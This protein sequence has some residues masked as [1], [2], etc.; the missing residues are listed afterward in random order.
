[1]N[2]FNRTSNES[3]FTF[4]KC[5]A[6][7]QVYHVD[8]TKIGNNRCIS[9]SITSQASSSLIEI[10]RPLFLTADQN[11]LQYAA[12]DLAVKEGFPQ[13][14]NPDSVL[15]LEP[16]VLMADRFYPVKSGQLVV[17]HRFWFFHP[18]DHCI[19][20]FFK[21]EDFNKVSKIFRFISS[22]S[23]QFRLNIFVQAKKIAFIC[24]DR[25][26]TFPTNAIDEAGK[27]QLDFIE[28]NT[29]NELSAITG[30]TV[31]RKCCDINEVFSLDNRACIPD[32]QG[33]AT[34]FFDELRAREHN[35]L[36]FR[37]G[38]LNCAYQRNTMKFQLTSS[39][40]LQVDT[41]VEGLSWSG[42]L[43]SANDYCVDD[44]VVTSSVGLPET[45]NLAY[46]C[47][48]D[49]SELLDIDSPSVPVDSGTISEIHYEELMKIN[50]PKCCSSS[51]VVD[52]TTCQTLQLFDQTLDAKSIVSNALN[53]YLLDNFN[54]SSTLI[55]NASLS[56]G[57]GTRH[58][59]ISNAI[60]GSE[61][62]VK[63]KPLGDGD[64]LSLSMHLYVE[65][66]WD[67]D[68]TLHSFCV[69]LALL[70][71]VK[72]AAYQPQVFYCITSSHVSEHY[73]ILLCIS[74]AALLA[75]F[76][77]YFLVPTSGKMS[78]RPTFK[79]FVSE[80]LFLVLI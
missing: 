68:V 74:T 78:R 5:C 26:N 42:Q 79:L 41:D 75:T 63:F 18:E 13:D 48:E 15:L 29:S 40:S 33:H 59:M 35:Q 80:Q 9:Y 4:R 34:Q 36:F 64:K 31:V 23:L 24:T 14:C 19:E 76:I 45:I 6:P 43:F 54:I 27:L 16:D 32:Q 2:R 77:I 38:L 1:M 51:E 12:E 53:F 25:I 58:P 49:P 47:L 65:N 73:P 8:K 52:G 67:F 17:P 39:G 57:F 60:N 61:G 7:G 21:D 69:D 30:Q 55:S 37:I 70:R 3:K 22:S 28:S 72:E 46:F 11:S 62:T 10:P 50:A 66:Y 20:E 56:C 44:F 71:S